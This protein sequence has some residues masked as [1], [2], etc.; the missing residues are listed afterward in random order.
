MSFDQL[1][2][3][4]ANASIQRGTHAEATKAVEELERREKEQAIECE[5]SY[6]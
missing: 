5:K 2:H 1:K 6:K 3:S 4:E